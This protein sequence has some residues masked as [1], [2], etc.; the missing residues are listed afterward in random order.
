MCLLFVLLE[1]RKELDLTLTAVHVNHCLR[2]ED[3]DRDMEFVEDFCREH[4]VA[5]ISYIV[6]VRALCEESGLGEEET[7][8]IARYNIFEQVFN[9]VD[10][11]IVAT[12]H[13]KDDN[14]ETVIMNAVRGCGLA[15]LRGIEPKSGVIIRPLLCV[16]KKEI[17]EFMDESG[18]SFCTD[19]TNADTAYFRNRIRLE[20]IPYMEEHLNPRSVEHLASLAEYAGEA[21]GFIRETARKKLKKAAD[22][23]RLNAAQLKKQHPVVAD[24]MIR[25]MIAG[26]CRSL[27]DIGARHIEAVRGLLSKQTGSR[28]DLPCGVRVFR[29]ADALNFLST[30]AERDDVF[31]TLETKPYS[32]EIVPEGHDEKWF[33]A[34]KL[35]GEP[36]VRRPEPGDYMV[37]KGGHKK[38]LNRIMIDDKIP[39]EYRDSIRVLA[40]GDHVIWMEGGRISEYYKVS[41][42]T[43]NIM[44]LKIEEEGK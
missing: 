36:A 9:D 34:G 12:A 28:V 5:V 26:S 41:E 21:Y 27:K 37:I 10:A 1:L 23:T 7:G 31:I 3:A 32:G 4:D 35:S 25:L 11:D 16:T 8:R 14:A 39:A 43:D 18:L 24:E 13:H 30:E 17:L 19:E 6:D 29:D 2:G 40:D 33:D 42:D 38:K 44:I 15:G 20:A 22:G